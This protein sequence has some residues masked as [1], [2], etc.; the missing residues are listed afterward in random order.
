MNEQKFYPRTALIVLTLLNLVNYVDRSVLN[1]VQPLIQTEFRLTKTELGYLTS[2]F[3]VFYMIAAPFVG[4]L[5]DRYSRKVI[6]ALGAFFWSGLTLLTAV[7][8]NYAELLV[9]HTLVG[10]GEAT[11]AKAAEKLGGTTT[12]R[13]F[14]SGET[15]ATVVS[16]PFGR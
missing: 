11:D 5:A 15:H 1:A 8:H 14:A 13:L 7:T 6:I 2:A 10:I 9:R 4:P 12:A 3:L 16:L